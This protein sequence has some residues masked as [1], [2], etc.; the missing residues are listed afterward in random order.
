MP[1]EFSLEQNHP[2]P[3]SETTTIRYSV[4]HPMHIRLRVYDV[5]GREVATLVD[6]RQGSGIYEVPFEANNLPGGVYF[7]RIT[8][9]HLRF[10]RRMAIVR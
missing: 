1:E 2:N 9:D 8:L 6:E 7:Y 10:T 4:P 5:L 3:F